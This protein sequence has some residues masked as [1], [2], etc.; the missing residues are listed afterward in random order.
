MAILHP[1]TISPTKDELV[2]P[3]L[4]SQLWWDGV[5]ERDP[6]GA[7]RFDDPAGEVGM[8]AFL[9]GSSDGRTLFVPLTYRG[10]ELPGAAAHLLG[11]MEHSVLGRRWV[12]DACADPVFVATLVDV[13]RSGG[14]QAALEVH[15]ADGSVETRTPTAQVRGSGAAELVSPGPDAQVSPVDDTD[16]TVVRVDDLTITVARRVGVELPEGSALTAEYAGGS[17]LVLASVS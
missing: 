8:E 1:A 7:F 17:G 16:R 13:I 3:W 2:T 5:E 4:R 6:V 9:L 15:R 12:Y 11:T 14:E 10:S